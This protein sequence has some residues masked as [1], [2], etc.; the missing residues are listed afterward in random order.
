M[1]AENGHVH[2]NCFVLKNVN[3]TILNVLA[4]NRSDRGCL[5]HA[6]DIEQR[7]ESHANT[8]RNG[9]IGK[10]GKGHGRKSNCDIGFREVKDSP[11]FAPLSHVVGHNDQFTRECLALIADNTLSGEKVATALNGVHLENCSNS[12]VVLPASCPATLYIK[13]ARFCRLAAAVCNLREASIIQR[14]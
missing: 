4:R 9:E 7:S 6:M 14:G 11:D 10:H 5:R 8:N 13:A 3:L 1:N 12:F 2:G